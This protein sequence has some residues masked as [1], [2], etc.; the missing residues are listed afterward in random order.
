MRE[1]SAEH[2]PTGVDIEWSGPA[3]DRVIDAI[4]FYGGAFDVNHQLPGEAETITLLRAVG[5]G[6]QTVAAAAELDI[7][8]TA[9]RV[10]GVGKAFGLEWQPG[11]PTLPAL[12]GRLCPPNS[13]LQCT[14]P[15]PID[16][17][18]ST[19]YLETLGHLAGGHRWEEIA[20]TANQTVR[21]L[22]R[23]LSANYC[24]E[25]ISAQGVSVAPM[26]LHAYGAD[27][28]V[29][30]MVVRKQA[31]HYPSLPLNKTAF[32]ASRAMLPLK[33]RKRA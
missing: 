18:P 24:S 23:H 16:R 6:P 28:L 10:R 12:V 33:Y 13:I 4:Q 7:W 29:P 26:L 20:A 5:V 15:V 14:A 3:N 1:V 11:Y 17:E 9:N 22:K 30:E 2:I 19:I 25:F 32:Y 31:A 21:T 8:S 27:L